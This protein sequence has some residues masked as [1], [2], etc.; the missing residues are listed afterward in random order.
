MSEKPARNASVWIKAFVVVHILGI[1]MWALPYPK[2]PYMLGTAKFAV[3]TSSP[4]AFARSFSDTVTQGILYLN[5][6]YLKLSPL[7]YYPGTTGF[8]QFWD[9]FS[10][11]PADTDLYLLADVT[12]KDGTVFRFHYPRVYDLPIAEKYL[13]ERYRKFF[14]NANQD[15]QAYAR[16]YVAQ[17]IALE[18]F[19]DPANPPVSVKLLRNMYPIKPPGKPQLTEYLQNEVGTYRIDQDKLWKDKGFAR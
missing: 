2:K 18:C 5:W 14:E 6:R 9:M 12:Y 19:K 4:S 7:M 16:P 10:P 1:T 3:D 11:D 17:R 8:W 13:K 15:A